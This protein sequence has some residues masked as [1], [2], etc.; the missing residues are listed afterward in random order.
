MQDKVGVGD[1]GGAGGGVCLCV[2]ACVCPDL[3]PLSDA[4][5]NTAIGPAPRYK[6]A[7]GDRPFEAVEVAV[8][9]AGVVTLHDLTATGAALSASTREE[10]RRLSVAFTHP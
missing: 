9:E 1:K 4:E 6:F 2:C 5:A 10:M 3:K 7:R 8:V